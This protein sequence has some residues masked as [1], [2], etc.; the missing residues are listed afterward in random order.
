M[1]KMME[2]LCK[3]FPDPQKRMYVIE[4]AAL[5][6]GL[7]LDD[8][9]NLL[10]IDAN[11]LFKSLRHMGIYSEENLLRRWHILP[12]LGENRQAKFQAFYRNLY[13]CYLLRNKEGFA[14][15]LRDI[16]DYYYKAL[17]EKINAHEKLTDEDLLVI[18][19]NQIKYTRS[20]IE[21]ADELG[22]DRNTYRRRIAKILEE[23][24][25][26]AEE[27]QAVHHFYVVRDSIEE[28]SRR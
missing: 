4:H 5:T 11:E 14:K 2:N 1:T 15:N 10:G 26:Y 17:K 7:T 25:E 12:N 23:H 27:Y 24:P 20:T 9:S 21:I 8:L 28:K 16:T 3:M 13:Q 19:R 22:M 6:Y 18:L